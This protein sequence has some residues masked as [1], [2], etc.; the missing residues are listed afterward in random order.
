MIIPAGEIQKLVLIE[1]RR[2]AISSNPWDV[3]GGF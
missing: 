1:Y 2:A 3:S